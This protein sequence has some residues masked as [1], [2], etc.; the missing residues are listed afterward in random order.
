MNL[1]E[2]IDCVPSTTNIHL[3]KHWHKNSEL[4]EITAATLYIAGYHAAI[5]S[6]WNGGKDFNGLR[7]LTIIDIACG[8]GNGEVLDCSLPFFPLIASRF[9][10]KVYGLD[11]LDFDTTDY[12]HRQINLLSFETLNLADFFSIN[13]CDVVNCNGLTEP[14]PSPTL[15]E[16]IKRYTDT[17]KDLDSLKTMIITAAKQVVLSNGLILYGGNEI[18][19]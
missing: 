17:D 13:N 11:F 18:K 16:L 8:G 1:N 5:I 9:G 12:T 2:L 15:L 6:K 14:D 7:D 10:A 4:D 19:H 3:L